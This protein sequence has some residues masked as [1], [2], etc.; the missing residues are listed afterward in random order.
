VKILG[1]VVKIKSMIVDLATLFLCTSQ[2]FNK[3]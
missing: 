3:R 2:P 1:F